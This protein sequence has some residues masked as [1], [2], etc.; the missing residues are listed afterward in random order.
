MHYYFL[1]G[2]IYFSHNMSH[3]MVQSYLNKKPTIYVLLCT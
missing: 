3:L 1:A 2:S